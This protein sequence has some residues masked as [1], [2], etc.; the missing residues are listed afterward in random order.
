MARK[1]KPSTAQPA[2]KPVETPRMRLDAMGTEGLIERVVRGDRL[3]D[4]AADCGAHLYSMQVWIAADPDRK[5]RFDVAM[6]I[7][8]D[9]HADEA[10]AII[11]ALPRD[12]TKADVAK[13]RELAQQ[14][15]W[16][17]KM[18]D[19]ERYSE[20][21]EVAHTALPDAAE[22]LGELRALFGVQPRQ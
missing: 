1:A 6:K 17:A 7:S 5:A 19:K 11:A 8:A 15:R 14:H 3:R 12:A 18:R 2:E 9:W 13:A 22:A 10:T 20:R 16:L 21:V 4:I